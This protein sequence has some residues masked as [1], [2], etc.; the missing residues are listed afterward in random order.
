[1]STEYGLS[2]QFYYK[3]Q[4][5]FGALPA[6]TGWRGVERV[7]LPEGAERAQITSSAILA[8]QQR[9]GTRQ[10]VGDFNLGLRGDLTPGQYVEFIETLM[11]RA[12]TAAV[13]T[14][15][16]TNVTAA[17]GPPGTFTRAAGSFIT[18]G[19][20]V[21]MIVRW[22]GWA[23]TGSGNNSRNYRI[24]ALSAT[25]MTVTGLGN[26]VVGAK[27]SGDSVTC[28]L[29]G[30]WTYVPS[31][32]HLDRYIAVESWNPNA[33][34]S[35]R[36]INLRPGNSTIAVSGSDMAQLQM[37][38]QGTARQSDATQYASSPTVAPTTKRLAGLTG[39]LRVGGADVGVITGVNIN[40]NP[41]L[42]PG[43]PVLGSK[44]RPCLA[45]GVLSVDGELTGYFEDRVL[46]DAFDDETLTSLHLVLHSDTGVAADFVSIFLPRIRVFADS[47]SDGQGP[48]SKTHRFS[49]DPSWVDSGLTAEY[50]PTTMM[51]QDSAA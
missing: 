2:R 20:R 21:G 44:D 39:S 42:I 24:T 8:H 46:S 18:D 10:G 6:N 37:P 45:P 12:F 47:R 5:T 23:T 17:A 14:G 41:N 19:F 4:P 30:K 11:R 43:D 31:T 48:V 9:P 35:D 49:A 38:L 40:I 27:A 25:V 28:T 22:T 34:S 32:G 26:E 29:V 36:Y 3:V 7:E 1:M 33:A 50:E 51:I 15:A 16:L 13:T